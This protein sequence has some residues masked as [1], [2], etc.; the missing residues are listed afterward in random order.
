MEPVKV[1]DG[2]IFFVPQLE[3]LFF[4]EFNE[5]GGFSFCRLLWHKNRNRV[6]FHRIL[7]VVFFFTWLNF[8][9]SVLAFPG[10]EIILAI[11]LLLY[12]SRY[13]F[14]A[15]PFCYGIVL[16]EKFLS[17]GFTVKFQLLTI[18]SISS[19]S[20]FTVL[21]CYLNFMPRMASESIRSSW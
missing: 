16:L 11:V 10:S 13:L 15:M 19:I 14:Y 12:Y 18:S 8:I 7:A 6:L 4:S 17:L 3:I 5:Y 20:A 21:C 2:G 1:S 9:S